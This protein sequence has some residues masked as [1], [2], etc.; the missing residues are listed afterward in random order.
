MDIHG[1]ADMA[2]INANVV[3]S[4]LMWITN[5]IAYPY[6]IMSSLM[7]NKTYSFV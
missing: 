6:F 2:T 5:V 3:V 1:E 7:L 4:V